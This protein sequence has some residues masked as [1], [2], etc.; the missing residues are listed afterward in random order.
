MKISNLLE[1]RQGLFEGLGVD[2]DP[3][4]ENWERNIHPVLI[5]MALDPEKIKQLF[6]ATEKSVTAAGG[7]R[8]MLGKGA[9]ALDA[10][11]E[12]L[13]DFWY[14]K[15]GS[16][17]Q[18]SAP[19]KMF[20]EKFE[21][22]KAKIAAKNPKLAEALSKYK[23][24]ADNNPKLQKFLFAVTATLATTVGISAAGGLAA[25]AGA[26]ALG[27][28]A[29]T[30]I[31]NVVDKLLQGEKLSTAV[32]RGATAGIVAGATAF[33]GAKAAELLGGLIQGATKALSPE[34]HQ[35]RFIN[36][37]TGQSLSAY[38]KPEDVAKFADLVD[39]VKEYTSIGNKFAAREAAQNL[40]DLQQMMA[41]PEYLQKIA[42]IKDNIKMASQIG[43]AVQDTTKVLATLATAFVS[44]KA[45]K[46]AADAGKK[47]ST[48]YQLR[49][50]S[51]GQVYLIFNKI[52]SREI[53]LE[54]EGDT[55]EKKGFLGNLKSNM[56]NKITADKL[57]K[58][59]QKAGAPTDSD[60]LAAFL[61]KQ[62][63]SA[64]IVKQIYTDMKL[65][66][67]GTAKQ[68]KDFETVKQ[69][70]LKLPVDRRARLL[71][72]LLGGSKGIKQQSEIDADR[73]RLI[74]QASEDIQ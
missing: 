37:A 15:L 3:Y 7:N 22:L 45:G 48:E 26:V 29:A 53:I 40:V 5:E 25:G 23:Q 1:H 14:N 38:G 11:K 36:G 63:V 17:L 24:F 33:L 43:Q 28:G 62:G 69:M 67:P 31:V 68:A 64:D 44:A 59:W 56:L 47:E 42:D 12:K 20:D 10:G 32:G 71:K 19:I 57:N 50:L 35:Y 60:E 8:T 13:K 54:A 41:T 49:P 55:E 21:D 2:R 74:P 34:L 39:Q 72:S 4:F 52:G 70:V 58:A 18:N 46:S 51:E 65:P 73:E 9:D 30:A 27:A 66:A 6:A 61:E 16:A